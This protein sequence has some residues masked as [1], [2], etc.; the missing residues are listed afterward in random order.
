MIVIY[1]T[2][3]RTQYPPTV[4]TTLGLPIGAIAPYRYRLKWIQPS[5]R[6]RWR[7][8]QLGGQPALI[9]FLEGNSGDLKGARGYCV[10]TGTVVR[11]E[12]EHAYGVIHV[13][14][15][16]FPA[17]TNLADVTHLAN[18][19]NILSSGPPRNAYVLDPAGQIVGLVRRV[20]IVLSVV[21]LHDLSAVGSS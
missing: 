2:D 15:Q 20:V 10:R 3:A 4:L 16:A 17:V 12:I 18:D 5:L 8:N 6:D 13:E 19:S 7:A 14:L 9:C 21:G 11:S 1:I